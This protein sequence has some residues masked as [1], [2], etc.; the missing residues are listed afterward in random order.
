[1]AATGL[2]PLF[3]KLGLDTDVASLQRAATWLKLQGANNVADLNQLP[4]G[5]Y[6]CKDLA[7]DLVLPML[8]AQRLLSA[9]EGTKSSAIHPDDCG[10]L[11]TTGAQQ[12][13][14][15]PPPPPP[16]Q[17][18]P[19]PPVRPPPR[20]STQ[21]VPCEYSEY[22][23]AARAHQ[24]STRAQRCIGCARAACDEPAQSTRTCGPV[25]CMSESPARPGLGCIGDCAA[26]PTV[27]ARTRRRCVGSV[28]MRRAS[29][30]LT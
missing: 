9:L 20:L 21:S 1:M 29:A 19:A 30:V 2:V 24:K 15:P 16:P 8:K 3:Q 17:S 14:S 23:P 25:P 28:T 7:D 5:T 4:P 10:A 18:Q 12:L 26:D 6:S 11:C 22:P 13:H 27:L